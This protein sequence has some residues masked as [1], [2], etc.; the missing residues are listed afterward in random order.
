MS[1]VVAQSSGAH[2]HYPLSVEYLTRAG[3]VPLCIVREA[4]S[5]V[6]Y[7]LGPDTAVVLASRYLEADRPLVTD[8][9]VA[10]AI[11]ATIRSREW[12]RR[13]RMVA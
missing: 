6:G 3:Y 1:T 8:E 13:S 4:L 7:G 12:G 10:K 5:R 9:A 11:R 2:D